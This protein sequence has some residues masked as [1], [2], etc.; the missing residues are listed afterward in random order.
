MSDTLSRL[1]GPSNVGSGTST[2]FTGTS[3]HTYTLRS[4]RIVN[5]TNSAIT[6]KLGIGGV[7]DADLI[8]PEISVPGKSAYHDEGM[9]VLSGTNTLQANASASG[10]TATVCGLDQLP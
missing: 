10:L 8:T 7:T 4:I 9:F 3:G 2:L 1:V 6:I 5:N